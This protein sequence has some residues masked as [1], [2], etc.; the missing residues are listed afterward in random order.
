[1]SKVAVDVG[2][3]KKEIVDVEENQT[4]HKRAPL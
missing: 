2:H 3:R 4:V 1:M